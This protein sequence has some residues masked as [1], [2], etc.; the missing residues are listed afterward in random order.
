VIFTCRVVRKKSRT[1]S[2]CS[3][4]FSVVLTV[5]RGRLRSSAARLK[6]SSSAI[7]IKM[8]IACI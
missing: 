5:A 1:P 3:S 2:F 6:F 8:R 7:R 4:A